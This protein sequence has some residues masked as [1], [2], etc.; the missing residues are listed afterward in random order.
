[1]FLEF[2][3]GRVE[4]GGSPVVARRMPE[5][6]SDRPLWWCSLRRRSARRR[7]Y[8][9]VEILLGAAVIAAF[10]VRVYQAYASTSGADKF[11]DF[12]SE[13]AQVAGIVIQQFLNAPDYSGLDTGGVPPA[14]VTQSLPT[15]YLDGSGNIV[16]V[17]R[18]V[19]TI[20]PAQ[21]LNAN[22][23]F[24]ITAEG[25]PVDACYK[26]IAQDFGKNF[27]FVSTSGSPA[28]N[29]DLQPGSGPGQAGEPSNA[30]NE[31]QGTGN[32]TTVSWLVQ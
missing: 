8:S 13:M 18:G 27:M 12:N 7:G 30:A 31:C 6:E 20:A 14:A 9:L 3:P 17:Y 25:L 10:L 15:K 32:T 29:G 26:A 24:T 22:D 11:E 5:P 21:N 4:A 23:S 28:T 1:M 16:D 19:V 2:K